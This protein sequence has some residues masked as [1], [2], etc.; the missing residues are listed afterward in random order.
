MEKNVLEQLSANWTSIRKLSGEV[1]SLCW[2]WMKSTD[3][4]R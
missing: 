3:K 2:P 4:K 1:I